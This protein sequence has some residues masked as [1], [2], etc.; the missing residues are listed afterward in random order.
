M[1]A[2]KDFC[3]LCNVAAPV[4]ITLLNV[5]AR[6][7]TCHHGVGVYSLSKQISA[8][9]DLRSRGMQVLLLMR[10]YNILRNIMLSLL[11]VVWFLT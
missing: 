5:C 8:F 11:F 6:L 10:I 9:A 1:K 7:S 3:V 4:V 2:P